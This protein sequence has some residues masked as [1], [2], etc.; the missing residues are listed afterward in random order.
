M[1]CHTCSQDSDNHNLQR[2]GGSGD[3]KTEDE[4]EDQGKWL[5]KLYRKCTYMNNICTHVQYGHLNSNVCFRPYYHESS[6]K[7][8]RNIFYTAIY[9]YLLHSNPVVLALS[10]LNW[11][12][13]PQKQSVL[14]SGTHFWIFITSYLLFYF[15]LWDVNNLLSWTLCNL[16]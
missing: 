13:K 8:N 4:K 10:Y 6:G 7:S 12:Q 1:T 16:R 14:N 3:Q 9:V 15:S 5:Y 2:D 11:D